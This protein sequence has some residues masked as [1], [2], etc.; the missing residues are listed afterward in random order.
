MNT[1]LIGLWAFGLFVGQNPAPTEPVRAVV[2]SPQGDLVYAGQGSS[3][4]MVN[5]SD[6]RLLKKIPSGFSQVTALALS[7]DGKKLAMAEGNPGQKGSIRIFHIGANRLPV[8][9]ELVFEAHKDLIH[10]L[11]FHPNGDMLASCS[12]D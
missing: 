6:G 3:L 2:Y 10:D 11:A 7:K 5:T 9:G 8:D 12:Y 1:F 4:V